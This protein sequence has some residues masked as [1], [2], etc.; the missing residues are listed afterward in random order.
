[1]L[2][3]AHVTK[4]LTDSLLHALHKRAQ[5]KLIR[6]TALYVSDL[7]FDALDSSLNLLSLLL[8]ISHPLLH[9][10][11]QTLILS[12]DRVNFLRLNLEI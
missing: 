7:L 9:C 12:L 5:D 6:Q 11:L 10:L 3:G 1:M 4:S 2:Q 8:Y